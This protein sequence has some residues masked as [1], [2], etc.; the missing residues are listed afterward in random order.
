MDHP[1][2]EKLGQEQIQAFDIRAESAQQLAAS[3]S[4]GNQKKIVIARAL[5]KRPT[6]LV[7]VFPTRGLDIGAIEFIHNRMT[8]QRDEGCA[9]LL[10]SNELDEVLSL[11]DRI[12]VMYEGQMR[13]IRQKEAWDRQSLGLAMAG[14]NTEE[15]S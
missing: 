9:I 5:H 15:A 13:Q 7:A 14:T 1:K 11:G 6:L 12:G 8:M 2:A 3:L 10:V 4:G